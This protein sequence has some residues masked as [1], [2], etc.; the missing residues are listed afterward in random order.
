M[1]LEKIQE[2]LSMEREMS[3]LREQFGLGDGGM[4]D[5][6]VFCEEV[7]F[8]AEILKKLEMID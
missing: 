1:R 7:G 8:L 3:G 5:G 2:F 6:H 4:V